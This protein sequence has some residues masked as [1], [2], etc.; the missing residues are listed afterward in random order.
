MYHAKENVNL[1]VESVIQIKNGIMINA[2]PSV[3][4]SY[5]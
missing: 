2:N 5:M 3:K 1:M 4:T